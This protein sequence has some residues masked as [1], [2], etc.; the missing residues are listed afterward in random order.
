MSAIAYTLAIACASIG[1]FSAGQASAETPSTVRQSRPASTAREPRLGPASSYRALIARHA[2][3]EGLPVELADAVVRLE[4]RYDAG[5]CN[6]P[7]VGLTQIHVRTARSL[8][9]AGPVA[10]LLDPDT[11]LR[12]GLAYLAQAYRLAGG[13]TCRT[14]LKYQAGHRALTMTGAARAYCGRVRTIMA[15]Q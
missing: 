14:I 5:A 6:G 4:S 15:R 12:Y 1:I 13:D 7:N 10:G 11:N 9:Y 8:G 2:A 3:H